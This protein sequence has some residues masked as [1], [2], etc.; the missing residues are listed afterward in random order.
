MRYSSS[1][2]RRDTVQG[3]A[4]V[5]RAVYRRLGPQ[6]RVELAVEMSEAARAI[7]ERSIVERQ[8]GYGPQQVRAALLRR[9]LG[10]EMFRRIWTD[11]SRL[12]S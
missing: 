10:D 8:P 5:Q 2:E 9:V 11:D 12:S 3:A 4:E 7:A 6:R 1:V